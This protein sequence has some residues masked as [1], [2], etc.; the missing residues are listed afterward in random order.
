MFAPRALKLP[1][2]VL[3]AS[4]FA[5]NAQVPEHII[6]VAKEIAHA[7]GVGQKLT[8]KGKETVLLELASNYVHSQLSTIK[9]TNHFVEIC[10]GSG[11]AS[12]AVKKKGA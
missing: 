2:L 3:V 9:R 4:I 1:V 12:K 5:Y 6:A 10:C 11:W 7:N 8:E